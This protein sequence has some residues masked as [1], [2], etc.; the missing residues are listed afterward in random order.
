M[1]DYLE[2]RGFAKRTAN[3][4]LRDWL[5]SRQ[6]YWGTP[7]P[8]VYCGACGIVPVPEQEL[9]VVLPNDV[10]FTSS[11]NSLAS[12][13][14]FVN[15][16]C[17]RCSRR[18]R[19]ET[20]TMDTFVD[21][22][23]Y[24]FRY[25]DN[26]NDKLPFEKG[27]AHA[28]MPVDQYIGGIEHAILHLLYA[29][30]F[31]KALRDLGLAYA[32]EPFTRLL[33]QGMVLKDGAKM[34]KSL[35]NVVD[36]GEI[37]N[38]YG[39]DTAR[40]FILFAA[41]PEKE[42]EWSEQGVEGS[43]RLLQRIAALFE[44][45]PSVGGNTR[46]L[47]DRHLRSQTHRTIKLV[48]RHMERFEFSF[49]I[50]KINEL[51]RALTRYRS[52]GELNSALYA[53]SLT[54]LTLLISPFAPHLAEEL[55]E[56]LGKKPFVSAHRWPKANEKYIDPLVEAAEGLVDASIADIDGILKLAAIRRPQ[57]ISI[58]I[59]EKWKYLFIGAVRQQLAKTRN[60]GEIIRAVLKN[61]A[62]RKHGNEIAKLVPKLAADPSR[63]P[64]AEL[65]Q[66]TELKALRESRQLIEKEFKCTVEIARA[67]KSGEQKA[68]Q[69]MPG[70]PGIVVK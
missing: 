16:A 28:W 34:S 3:Y 22:S 13:E 43:Y 5:I 37:I 50:G 57:R 29:R 2:K 48:T 6:R 45:S 24:F 36:P 25:C 1:L 53:E 27:K 11:G 15:A 47:R 49:A 69:A 51:A 54:A 7:I 52:A 8:I 9:P 42:L 10:T 60:T 40:V 31:T 30:F 58:F 14:S 23:W 21:S 41:L 67:E 19:R 44:E 35:G 12:S 66:K 64:A 46:T 32:S 61:A 33:T 17:P 26:K 38:R 63:L 18:A 59:A 70:K 62:L 20:D 68:K 55:W 65:E 56:K 4:K 39:A